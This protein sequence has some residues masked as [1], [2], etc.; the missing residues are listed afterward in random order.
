MLL[1]EVHEMGE[2]SAMMITQHQ[3]VKTK[4]VS[5][6]HIAGNIMLSLMNL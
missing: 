3:V 2:K 1:L 6:Y 5:N 4:A